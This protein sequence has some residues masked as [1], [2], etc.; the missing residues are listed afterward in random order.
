M[1]HDSPVS[2][3]SP[4][5]AVAG[6]LVPGAGYWVIGQ[7]VRSLTIGLTIIILFILGIFIAGIRVVDAPNLVGRRQTLVRRILDKPAFLGQ[8]LTGPLGLVSAW[9]SSRAASNPATASIQA[10]SRIADIGALYTALAGMLNL[11][12]IFDA[13][14]RSSVQQEPAT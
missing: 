13:A 4:L 1:S 3:P 2:L 9:A 5:V 10:H 6:W 12:A 8:V 7:R 14:A 11:M